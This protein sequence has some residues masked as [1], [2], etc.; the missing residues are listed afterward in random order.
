MIELMIVIAIIGILRH[1][2]PEF[3]Q[4]IDKR[5]QNRSESRCQECYTAAQAYF[6]DHHLLQFQQY[7]LRIT[8][9]R[10]KLIVTQ[11]C[12][13]MDG[14]AIT[15]KHSARDIHNQVDAKALLPIII[16]DIYFFEGGMETFPCPF[17]VCQL[18]FAVQLCRDLTSVSNYTAWLN[19]VD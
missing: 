5:L 18:E 8:D 11:R 17:L 6:S 10:Q 7:D 15:A 16:T 4:Y 13:D 3:Q 12:C 1:R 14:L 9:S 19:G 2:Q